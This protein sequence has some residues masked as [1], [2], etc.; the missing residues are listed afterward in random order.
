MFSREDVARAL[1]RAADEVQGEARD[2]PSFD[3][4]VDATNLTVAAP[5]A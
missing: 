4:V 1:S 3:P 5:A 2:N